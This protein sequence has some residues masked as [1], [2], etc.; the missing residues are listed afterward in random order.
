MSL[1]ATLTALAYKIFL[2]AHRSGLL[3]SGSTKKSFKAYLVNVSLPS[4]IRRD[5]DLMLNAANRFLVF[6]TFLS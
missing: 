3:K 6:A 1:H 4:M 2:V 5:V